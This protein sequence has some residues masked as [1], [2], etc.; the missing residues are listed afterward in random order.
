MKIRLVAVTLQPELVVDDG[1]NLIKLV[2]DPVTV[3]S[4]DWPTVVQI[5]ADAIASLEMKLDH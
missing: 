1:S 4:Q 2:V 3:S 5:L